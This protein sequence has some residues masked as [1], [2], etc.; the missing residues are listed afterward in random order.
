MATS[1]CGKDDRDRVEAGRVLRAL[2]VVRAAPN[3]NK[4]RPADE[5]ATTPC[6][7]P[8]VCNTRD[9]CGEAYQHLARGTDAA[10]RVKNELDRIEKQPE[11]GADKMTELASELD[12]ADREIGGARDSLR[13][14]EEAA[15]LMRRTFGI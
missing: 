8:I 13:R 14:C 12:R 4:R 6:S 3:E 2:E 1:G 10:L 15:S 11:G 5:L 7:S 9:S